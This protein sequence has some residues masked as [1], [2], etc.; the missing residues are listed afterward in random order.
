MASTLS[1]LC[2]R[3]GNL[4]K[5]AQAITGASR[6]FSASG[7]RSKE[8]E[9]PDEITHATGI[10]KYELTQAQAGNDDPFF[11]KVR[12]RS[13]F[14]GTKDEPIIVDAMDT[15]RLVGCVCEEHDCHIKWMWLIEGRNKRCACGHWFSLKA[16]PAP[17]RYNLPL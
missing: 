17:D 8:Y 6:T 16:H 2:L 15:F 13:D 4:L 9:M 1:R 7:I 14:K 5:N 12:A 3:G 11:L 10:E